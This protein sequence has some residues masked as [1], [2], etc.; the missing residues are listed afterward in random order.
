MFFIC[1]LTKFYTV[2][3]WAEDTAP[4]GSDRSA[5]PGPEWQGGAKPPCAATILAQGGKSR[6]REGRALA[7]ENASFLFLTRCQAVAAVLVR[8]LRGPHFRTWPWC[9]RRSS[10]EPTAAVSPNNFPQSSTGLFDVSSVL[11]RS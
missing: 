1:S 2:T 3:T 11:Q 8:Q 6:E 9:S 10:I 4:L 5:G 7:L